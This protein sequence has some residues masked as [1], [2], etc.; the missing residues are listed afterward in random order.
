VAYYAC[1]V[2]CVTSSDYDVKFM[3]ER[4]SSLFI[5][6]I[7]VLTAVCM[8]MAVFWDVAQFSL[9]DTVISEELTASIIRVFMIRALMVEAL[10]VPLKCQSTSRKQHHYTPEDCH[11]QVHKCLYNNDP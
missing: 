4:N 8:K 10:R 2:D 11:L 6:E 5:G 1:T 7:Q 9:V 3:Y